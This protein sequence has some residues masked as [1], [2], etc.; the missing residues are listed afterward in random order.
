MPQPVLDA[1]CMSLPWLFASGFTLAY[2]A[3]F[4]KIYRINQVYRSAQA[5]QRI[6]IYPIDVLKPLIVLMV[7]NFSILIVWTIVSPL[8]YVREPI[9]VDDYGRVLESFG[10]CALEDTSSWV[11]MVVTLLI[12]GAALIIA[13]YQS[14]LARNLPS[15]WN[16][17]FYVG[18]TNFIM[19]ETAIISIPV[20][21]LVQ[22]EPDSFLLCSCLCIFVIIMAVML[23]AFLPKILMDQTIQRPK[24]LRLN[25]FVS[26][27]PTR[28]N[29]MALFSGI[30]F[31][32]SQQHQTNNN[33]NNNNNNTTTQASTSTPLSDQVPVHQERPRQRISFLNSQGTQGT[34]RSSV[35]N[36]S[37]RELVGPTAR[38][39]MRG[40]DGGM[41]VE[42][43][44]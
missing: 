12:N 41:G 36:D 8:T 6:T 1:A 30:S 19:L 28:L 26:A 17:S 2:A 31:R 21:V 18:L 29:P 20:F 9:R 33:N 37:S 25:R 3:L 35:I 16:E 7:L 39:D 15:R 43:I 4:S 22:R 23:P 27:Y 5:F 14:Y 32:L 10:F 44:L 13:N 38:A 40:E 34:S 24:I 42:V 11:C